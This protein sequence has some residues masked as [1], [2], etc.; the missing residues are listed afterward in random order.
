MLILKEYTGL[1]AVVIPFDNADI[2][3]TSPGGCTPNFEAFTLTDM[4]GWKA[5]K[6]GYDDSG[7]WVGYY[8]TEPPD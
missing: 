3:T 7:N 5:C 1:E 8:N 6:E 2:I 4:G